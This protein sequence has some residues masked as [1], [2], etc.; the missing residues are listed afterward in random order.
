MTMIHLLLISLFAGVAPGAALAQAAPRER[1]LM[2][3]GWTFTTGD[4]AG[5]EAAAF[6]DT[7]WRTLDLPHDWSIEGLYDSAAATTGRGGYLPTGVGWYRRTFTV[8]RAW[9]G[10]RVTIEFDPSTESRAAPVIVEPFRRGGASRNAKP[11]REGSSN[12]RRHGPRDRPGPRPRSRPSPLC[13][14]PH[15]ASPTGLKTK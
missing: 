8:P 14:R 2:D 7:G 10:R 1:L 9:R 13:G 5:A 6:D 11:S 12:G 15:R 4:P 3:Y